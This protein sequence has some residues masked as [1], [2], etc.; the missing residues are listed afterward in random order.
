M[1]S[2]GLDLLC[3]RRTMPLAEAMSRVISC[4]RTRASSA[5]SIALSLTPL[6][7]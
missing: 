3:G 1:A 7:Y 2:D 5:F 6:G 4:K